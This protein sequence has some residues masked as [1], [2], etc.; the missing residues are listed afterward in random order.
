[1]YCIDSRSTDVYFNLAAEEYLLKR[2]RQDYFM[3]WQSEPSVVIGKNQSVQTE[4]NEECALKKGI[5]LARRF[6]GGGAVYHDK[7]NINLTFI[8]TTAQ[9]FFEMYLQ[10]V[11][12]FLETLGI[13]AYADKRL[14]LYVEGK[15]ISGSAQCI[16]K[17]RVMYHC[18]LLFATD[19]ALLETVLKENS[20]DAEPIPGLEAVRAV[21]SVHS[22]VTNIDCYLDPPIHIMRFIRLLFHYFLTEDEEN[23]IYHF[24][25]DD[26]SAIE[27][28]RKEKYANEDWIYHRIALKKI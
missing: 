18:T 9:P 5:H 22:A 21:P 12:D 6:S 10:R 19:L 26:L 23:A 16:H 20:S 1:M 7:G 17:D 27:R 4:V 25:K 14:G 24:S 15:K 3:V 13:S 8:E 2:K 28:L 11:V